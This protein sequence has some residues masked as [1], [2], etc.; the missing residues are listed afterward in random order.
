MK[1][2]NFI[3]SRTMFSVR[4]LMESFVKFSIS[5]HKKPG[6]DLDSLKFL[7]PDFIIQDP[8]YYQKLQILPETQSDQ[9]VK[10]GI[11]VPD[12]L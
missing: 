11:S 7:H 3:F 2:K 6:L 8:Q 10:E 4:G 12:L 5:S 9:A 1:I